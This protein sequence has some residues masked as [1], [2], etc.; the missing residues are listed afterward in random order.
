MKKI[1]IV[2]MALATLAGC[3]SGIPKDQY[4]SVVAERDSY[5]KELEELKMARTPDYTESTEETVTSSSIK[6]SNTNPGKFNQEEVMSQLDCTEY[7]YENSIGDTMYFLVVKNNS[8]YT[9]RLTSNAVAKDSEGKAIGA[10][11][12]DEYAV[13]SGFS[14]CLL[15][16]FGGVKDAE[17]IEYSLKAKED[18]VYAPVLS[19]LQYDISQTDK[20]AIITVS[21]TGNEAAKFVEVHGLFFKEGKFV[22]SSSTYCVDDDSELKPGDSISKDLDCYGSDF[23][24]VEI[25][26]SGRKN[27]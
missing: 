21:N 15:H 14:A 1:F 5:K 4:E 22:Y 13:E 27:K 16:Y 7:S 23:D 17:T 26:F 6:E 8:P 12:A 9:L 24:T 10:A 25:Y 19:D 11:D 3:S 20:K 2:F 18:S